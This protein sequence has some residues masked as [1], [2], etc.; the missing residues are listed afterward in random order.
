MTSSANLEAAK[1]LLSAKP[2]AASKAANADASL[3]CAEKLLAAGNKSAA[4]IT[5]E[6]LLANTPSKQVKDAA[7]RGVT[8][9]GAA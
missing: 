5:Y 1:A 6:K 4:K 2:M 7:T 3:H 8:A 9:C